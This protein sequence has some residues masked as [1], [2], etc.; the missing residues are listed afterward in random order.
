L[1][2]IDLHLRSIKRIH[3]NFFGNFDVIISR[4]FYQVQQVHDVGVFKINAN[5][6]DDLAPNFGWKKML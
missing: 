4:D 2:F 3:T 1:K 6:I 5:N